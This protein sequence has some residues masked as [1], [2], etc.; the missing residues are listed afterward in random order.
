MDIK[1]VMLRGYMSHSIRGAKG[2][3]CSPEE[4]QVNCTKAAQDGAQLMALFQRGGLPVFLY[5]PGANDEFVQKAYKAGRITEKEILD[6][7]C[8]IISECDFLLLYDWDDYIGG[9]KKVELDYAN[10]HDMPVVLITKLDQA[11]VW[12]MQIQLMTMLLSKLQQPNI[13]Q[14]GG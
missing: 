6:T 7:D 9:G 1:Q 11:E 5:V 4:M 3:A 2:G 12:G 13:I 14:I 8:E 10:E